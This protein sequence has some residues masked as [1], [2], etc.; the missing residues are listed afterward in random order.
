[1]GIV[2]ARLLP[3]SR[4]VMVDVDVAAIAASRENAVLNKVDDRTR[5]VLSDGLKQIPEERFDLAV[6][7]FPLHIGRD[8]L[9][10]LLIEIRNALEPGG[11]LWGVMLNAYELRPLVQRVFGNVDTIPV[12]ARTEE[13]GAYSILRASR[14]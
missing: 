6:T 12:N 9:N 11:R 3:A 8:E 5:A 14:T 4:I 10:R 13:E 1:M 7:H 2:L